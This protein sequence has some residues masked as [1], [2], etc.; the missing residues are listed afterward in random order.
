MEMKTTPWLRIKNKIKSL[1]SKE[2]AKGLLLFLGAIS[3]LVWANTPW[4][5]SYHHLWENYLEI[6]LGDLHFKQNL[7]HVINDGL[8]AIFFFLV[9][10]EIKREVMVGELSSIKKAS[11]PIL[12]A[13][14]GMLFPALIYFA[15]NTSGETAT[16][17][18]IPMATDIAFVLVILTLLGRRVPLALKVF[19]TALAVVD[20]LGAVLVIAFFY[21]DE[22]I[23]SS[24]Y[25]AF[26]VFLLLMGANRL[27][28]RNP[29]FY[30]LI[31]MVGVWLGFLQSGVHATIAG[32]LIAMAIPTSVLIHE[33]RFA[34]RLKN[35]GDKFDESDS[36]DHH[37]ITETQLEILD[38][39]KRSRKDVSPPLQ[40][41]E[42][43][44]SPFVDFFILP[45][46]ALANAGITLQGSFAENISSTVSLGIVAGL[47]IGKLVGIVGVAQIATR[48][49]IAHLPA[50]T[51]WRSFTGGAILAG[52]GFTMSLFIAELAFSSTALLNEAKLGVLIASVLATIIGTLIFLNPQKSIESKEPKAEFEPVNNEG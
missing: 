34:R 4:H 7:H 21:T 31:G 36:T 37:M 1:L 38:E 49:G 2:S 20:D 41:I 51:N 8:M 47:V 45:L 3:A 50:N 46:F 25:I 32:V 11:L 13:I 12:C 19:V 30:G 52:V 17:W 42:Y 9:G 48:L 24:L 6:S 39:V 43:A 29:W 35:L 23:W 5:E 15:M 33:D 40:R 44:L 28:I 27:G 16:G 14:G 26:A 10:L 22:I 18:G